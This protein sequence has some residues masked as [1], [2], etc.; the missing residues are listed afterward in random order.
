MVRQDWLD[1]A[2]AHG[3]D[4]ALTSEVTTALQ[5]AGPALCTCTTLGALAEGLGAIRIDRPMMAQAARIDGPLCLAYCLASTAD[6]SRDLLQSCIDTAGTRARIDPLPL[7]S[8]WPHFEAGNPTAFA[9]AI[10]TGVRAHLS[11]HPDTRAVLLAQASMDVAAPL[12]SDLPI[13][14]LTPGESA[15]LAGLARAG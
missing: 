12:L 4:A 14:V 11:L 9:D 2:R 6:A 15:L 5:Q 8:A 13:P 1:R 3:I 10:A 7:L